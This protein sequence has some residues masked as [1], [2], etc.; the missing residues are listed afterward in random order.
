MPALLV[1]VVA[2]GVNGKNFVNDQKEHVSVM[3]ILNFA[4]VVTG[5]TLSWSTISSDY[6]AYFHPN[7]PRFVQ[8][9]GSLLHRCLMVWINK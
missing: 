6:T 3:Q 4:S 1:F 7:V 9:H 2:A 8:F 5:F